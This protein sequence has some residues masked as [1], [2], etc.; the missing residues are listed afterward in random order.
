MSCIKKDISNSTESESE[1]VFNLSSI[2]EEISKI[3]DEEDISTIFVKD[4]AALKTEIKDL[5]KVVA[6]AKVKSEDMDLS[7][8]VREYNEMIYN[9]KNCLRIKLL[10]NLDKKDTSNY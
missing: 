8:D 6:D 4:K 9:N 10:L 2:H 3:V 1:S 7:K 5:A